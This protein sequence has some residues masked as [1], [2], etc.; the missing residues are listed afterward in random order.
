MQTAFFRPRH[1]SKK[2]K[3][4]FYTGQYTHPGI[5]MPVTLISS[6]IVRDIIRQELN[7]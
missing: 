5:G 7:K 1:R 2:V 6:Q 4:L 3:N